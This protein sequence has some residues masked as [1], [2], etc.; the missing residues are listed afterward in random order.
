M[1]SASIGRHFRNAIGY[2]WTGILFVWGCVLIP[3]CVSASLFIGS[4]WGE[5]GVSLTK[6]ASPDG[7]Y[8]AI[9]TAIDSGATDR[10][11]T[12]LKLRS[13]AND[14]AV[15]ILA[16]PD[17]DSIDVRWEAPRRLIARPKFLKCAVGASSV[18]GISVIIREH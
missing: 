6:L 16:C 4:G 10:G 14:E 2:P 9:L 17:V 3:L 15:D 13:V 18:L 7:D 1:S 5:A 8:E 12:S 11:M